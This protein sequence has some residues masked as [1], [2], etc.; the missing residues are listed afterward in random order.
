V[1]IDAELP[2]GWDEAFDRGIELG[3]GNVLCLLAI[4]VQP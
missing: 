3:D 1:H 2:A 4:A